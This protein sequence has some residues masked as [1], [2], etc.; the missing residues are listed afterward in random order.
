MK[1]IQTIVLFKVRG[2]SKMVMG[3]KQY[4][5]SGIPYAKP[6]VGNRRWWSQKVQTMHRDFCLKKIKTN[7]SVFFL[8]FANQSGLLHGKG[9]WMVQRCQTHASRYLKGEYVLEEGNFFAGKI[10]ILPW[11]FG[12][13]NVEPKHSN[14]RGGGKSPYHGD[15]KWYCSIIITTMRVSIPF[16]AWLP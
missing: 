2:F 8:D 1:S 15:D 13:R 5:F 3:K 6:P 12:R 11:F 7:N 10:W 16:V 4:L 14:I 9:C